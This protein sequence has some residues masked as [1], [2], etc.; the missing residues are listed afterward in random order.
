MVIGEAC[1][2]VRDT[3]PARPRANLGAATGVASPR[4]VGARAGVAAL[5][6]IAAP[7]PSI[8]IIRPVTRLDAL[9]PGVGVTRARDTRASPG[10]A[11]AGCNTVPAAV[12]RSARPH[13]GRQVPIG[14][15]RASVVAHHGAIASDHLRALSF[16]PSGD[17]RRSC[18][19]Y[20]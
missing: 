5:D 12:R 3:V 6:V 16:A 18:H 10:G 4:A 19:L 15:A 13:L 17:V 11:G 14:A 2:R 1:E 20:A 9:V 7:G 8:I